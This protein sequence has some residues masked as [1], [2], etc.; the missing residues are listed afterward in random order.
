ML[1]TIKSFIAELAGEPKFAARFED[2]DYRL[3]AAA[4]LVHAL[5]VDGTVSP[6]ERRKLHAVLKYRFNL[7]DAA[8]DEL[9]DEARLVEGE[10]VDLYRFTSLINR[11]LDEEG[12]RRIVE[13]MWELI[14]ADGRANE[15]EDNLVWRVADLLGISSRERIALK[16][17][18][19]ADSQARERVPQPE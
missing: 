14:Y 4:L 6:V 19:A 10:A 8:A 15:F 18:V 3:A 1:H 13:M 5:V 9:I 7:D 17:Q 16:Q 12:R 11:T 2:N